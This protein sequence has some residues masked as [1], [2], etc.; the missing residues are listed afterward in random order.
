MKSLPDR[1][2]IR[3]AIVISETKDIIKANNDFDLSK[4]G[5]LSYQLLEYLKKTPISLD[6]LSIKYVSTE[7]IDGNNNKLCVLPKLNSNTDE[8]QKNIYEILKQ[9]IPMFGSRKTEGEAFSLSLY[10]YEGMLEVPL[11]WRISHGLKKENIIKELYL[12]NYD[13]ASLIKFGSIIDENFKRVMNGEVSIWENIFCLKEPLVFYIRVPYSELWKTLDHSINNGVISY[14]EDNSILK[15]QIKELDED[16]DEYI[17]VAIAR[18]LY[19]L[20]TEEIYALYKTSKYCKSCGKPL[21]F[22]YKGNY[23]QN[24]LENKDCIKK[25][26]RK[27]ARK[28]KK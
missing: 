10:S 3:Y 28:L 15:N 19:S 21:P 24:V 25:R 17:V 26:G 9:N 18:G 13:E 8:W 27:R 2:P 6:D 4:R 12:K 1:F 7:C 14:S 5:S 23:C 22:G 20:V 16:D 11:F